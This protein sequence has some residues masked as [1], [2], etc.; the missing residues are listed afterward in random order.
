[1][2][3][4]L[5]PVS[6][7]HSDTPPSASQSTCRQLG[8]AQGL[9]LGERLQLLQGVVLDLADALTGDAEGAADLLQRAGVLALQPEAQLDHLALALGQRVERALDVLAAQ[10]QG[11]LVERGRGLL[12]L[13]EVAELGLLLLTD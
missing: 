1:M 8:A 12:V 6:F 5:Q 3:T 13:D 9:G 2:P 4:G 10:V 11:G 7:S